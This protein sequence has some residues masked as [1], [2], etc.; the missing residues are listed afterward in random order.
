LPRRQVAA[1]TAI[2][3][4]CAI[5]V[6][7]PALAQQ[8]ATKPQVLFTRVNSS[9]YDPLDVSEYTFE[10]IKATVDVARTWNTCV[11]VH[12]D[13][14]MGKKH[15]GLLAKLKR[16]YTP[17]QELRRQH[18]ERRDLQEHAELAERREF[19]YRASARSDLADSK[20][21]KAA[22]GRHPA[23]PGGRLDYGTIRRMLPS[24][25]VGENETPWFDV[26]NAPSGPVT[27]PLG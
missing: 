10:E 15:G 26:Y 24:P 17:Y 9:N 18:E 13:A 4:A 3:A 27:S 8:S 19:D 14:E 12:V 2:I 1:V 21:K 20:Q 22:R 5:V 16:W 11:A 6:A 23:P 7:G 25:P